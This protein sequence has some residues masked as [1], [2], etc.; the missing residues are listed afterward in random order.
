MERD[1]LIRVSVLCDL[2]AATLEQHESEAFWLPQLLD[3]LRAVGHHAAQELAQPAA[4]RE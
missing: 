4:G 1:V 3:E 2:S